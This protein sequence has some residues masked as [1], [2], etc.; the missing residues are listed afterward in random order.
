MDIIKA[1]NIPRMKLIICGK[2]WGIFGTSLFVKNKRKK[3]MGKERERER[4][5]EREIYAKIIK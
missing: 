1:I 5:R 4:E 2:F 3:G